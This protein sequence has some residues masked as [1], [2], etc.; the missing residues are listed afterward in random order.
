LVVALGCQVALI[1]A[2]LTFG[3]IGSATAAQPVGDAQATV[4]TEP[5]ASSG[6][7][8][9]DPAIWVDVRNP[10]HSA[11]IG[12]DKGG[13]LEVYDLAGQRLQ[14]ISEGFFGNV[15]VQQ[16]FVTGTGTADLAVVYRAGLRVY[17]IDPSTRQLS[18]ITDASNGSVPT[19]AGGEGLCLYKSPT[20]GVL[21]AFSNNPDGR[22]SQFALTDN[23][24]DGLV[25]GAQV[26]SWDV[27]SEIEACVA[28]NE[29]GDVYISEEDVGIWRYGAEPTDSTTAR[30]QVDE[31]IGAGGHL[32]NDV[33]GL[34]LV[35]QAG[36]QGYL[37][38]S[39]QGGS[40]DNFY[41]AYERQGSNA[42]LRTFRI[43]D[44]TATDGC[45][46]TDGIAAVAANLGPSFPRGV[47][48]CQDDRNTEPGSSGNQN[49]KLVPLE[50]VVDLGSTP[51]PPR[52]N[53]G[54]ISFRGQATSNANATSHEVTVPAG[55]AASDGM[56]LFFSSNTTAAVT[57][58]DGWQPLDEITVSGTTTQA[59][60]RVADAGDAG[61]VVR[62]E[63]DAY[64]KANLV[65]AAYG[66]TSTVDPVAAFAGVP[67]TVAEAIHTS[68][69]V[70]VSSPASWAV[71]Y[72]SHKDSVSTELTPPPEVVVRAGGTQSGY[73]RITTL[74]ADSDG[75][76][77]TGTYGGLAALAAAPRLAATSWTVILAPR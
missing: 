10:G 16:G 4:E 24:G 77:P 51:P 36:G 30:T 29:T 54:V 5:V 52:P 63:V 35:Y 47:F 60:R 7:A 1:A 70:D 20:S 46:H 11:V 64:S 17:R 8:A 33:E 43:V 39:A 76:V 37:L 3:G 21:Y 66:G 2:Y 65:L 6:D 25:E 69:Q 44:G 40:D 59:W 61:S 15:D 53:P 45:S 28:D 9:D 41:A 56:L 13:A 67:A 48:I 71:T 32:R 18:N 31:L 55:V 23:D 19:P 42:F 73:G 27:G 75:P 49:F 72:W 74:L 14:R 26:R 68:P 58:P 38:A 22:V 34:T 12:N 62:V 57:G 50:R